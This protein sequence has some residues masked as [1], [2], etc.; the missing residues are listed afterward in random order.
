M[1]KNMKWFSD[2][3]IAHLSEVA[4]EPNFQGTKYTLIRQLG[5]GGMAT[6]YLA[7][8]EELQREVAIKV[9]NIPDLNPDTANR[10]I[11][12]ARIISQLEHP[13]IVPVHDVGTL[14]DARVYYVM[15]LVRGQ[16]LDEYLAQQSSLNDRL[17]KFHLTCEAVAFAHAHSVIHRDL[18]PQNIMIGSFGEVL[19]LDWGVAKILRAKHHEAEPA[20]GTVEKVEATTDTAHGTII[21]TPLFMS[22]EQT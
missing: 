22:P 9:I 21:G 13:G 5:R 17:R 3:T 14:D 1:D 19:V 6:V 2:E 16:R 11:R 10:V 12:E 4:N 7:V 8:D 20:N 15:K 18:K